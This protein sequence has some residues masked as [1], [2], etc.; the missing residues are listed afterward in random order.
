MILIL[1]AIP[2]DANF[3]KGYAL[4]GSVLVGYVLK[5]RIGGICIGGIR[6]RFLLMH[7]FWMDT[8]SM[9]TYWWD[10]CWTDL[11]WWDT[12]W[13]DT[14][15]KTCWCKRFEWIR[16]AWIR[17]GGIRV[18]RIRIGGIRIGGI[19]FEWICVGY[20]WCDGYVWD[21]CGVRYVCDMCGVRYANNLLKNPATKRLSGKKKTSLGGEFRLC[22]VWVSIV[23]PLGGKD[24]ASITNHFINKC[25]PGDS[26]WLF[27]TF[28][29]PSWRSLN[30]R[31]GHCVKEP[32]FSCTNKCKWRH[33]LKRYLD[34][35]RKRTA[36]SD[37]P[38]FLSSKLLELPT[39]FQFPSRKT[40]SNFLLGRPMAAM[41]VLRYGYTSC[42]CKQRYYIWD[43]FNWKPL[44]NQR[45]FIGPI[46]ET[47]A[48]PLRNPFFFPGP[49][50]EDSY[51]LQNSR[52]EL[53]ENCLSQQENHLNQSTFIKGAI[54]GS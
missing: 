39:C 21:M 19:R 30:L 18:E 36:C 15:C 50:G 10:T 52:L 5:I 16:I 49:I 40:T 32:A 11:Y 27:M 17:T 38:F 4:N 34:M 14:Y 6:L 7:T 42:M 23:M 24:L 41:L 26:K 22:W 53:E 35:H 9:D 8:H 31:K 12:Y 28:L 20:V 2:A 46:H 37:E 3:L 13:W 47:M 25:V 51:T 43:V 44:S 1:I 29:S 48:Q 54:R 33:F 45:L